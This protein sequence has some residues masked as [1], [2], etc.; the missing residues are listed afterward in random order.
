MST[1]AIAV[2][3]D[4]ADLLGLLRLLFEDQ[5]WATVPFTDSTD[6][7]DA[8]KDVPP[9]LIMLD[10]WLGSTGSG[11]EVVRE[12]KAHPALHSVPVLICSGATDHRQDTERWLREHEITL[13][14]KPFDIDDLYMMVESALHDEGKTL[15]QVGAST[16]ACSSGSALCFPGPRSPWHALCP[17]SM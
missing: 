7:V 1:P 17:I 12:L 3:D 9:N 2:I 6:A 8:L 10:L 16:A 4:D 5:G 11:W 13:L 15:G 14:S